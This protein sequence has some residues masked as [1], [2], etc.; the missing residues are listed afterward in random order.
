[1]NILIKVILA[2]LVFLAVT[3]GITKL[4]LMQQDV[5]FFGKYGFTT[6]VLIIFG[7]AQL[8]GGI[9]L[10]VRK[11]RSLGAAIV[12]ITFLISVVLLVM[13]GDIPF[14]IFTFIALIMLG[15]VIRYSLVKEQN[16]PEASKTEN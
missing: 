7:A 13:E 9:L 16:T 14:T 8:M 6:P 4:M 12:A 11:T 15:V 2:I 1:M 10:L 3:S 5:E